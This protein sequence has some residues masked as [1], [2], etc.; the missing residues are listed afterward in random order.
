MMP[1]KKLPLRQISLSHQTGTN[2][3]AIMMDFLIKFGVIISRD[4]S[5]M[6]R[7]ISEN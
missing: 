5:L 3:I 1:R 6:E 7:E 2:L 4:T